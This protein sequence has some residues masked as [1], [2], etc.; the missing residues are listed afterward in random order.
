MASATRDA[1]DEEGVIFIREDDG[2]ITAKDLETG[3]ARGGDARAETLRHLSE[4]LEVHEGGCKPIEDPDTGEVRL[5]DV[6]QHDGVAIGTLRSIADQCGAVDDHPTIRIVGDE[7]RD[8]VAGVAGGD[9]GDRLD[10]R[11][12]DGDHVCSGI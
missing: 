9:V 3:L 1:P 8:R 4:A 12:P 11:L 6:P 2:S 5:V 7:Q 10:G